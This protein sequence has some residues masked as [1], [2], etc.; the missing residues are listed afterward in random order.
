MSQLS[1]PTTGTAESVSADRFRRIRGMTLDLTADLSE[2]DCCVQSQTCCSPV[3]WHLGHTSWFFERFIVR[4]ILGADAYDERFEFLFNS[5]YNAIGTRQPRSQRGLLTRPGL[6]E[7]MAFREVVDDRVSRALERGDLDD[8]GLALVELGLSHEQQHQEL[9]LMD[10][11]H[12]FSCSPLGVSYASEGRPA[13]AD[14]GPTTDVAF[15]GQIASIGSCFGAHP[16]IFDN[17]CPE[18]RVF[19]EPFTLADRLVTN[20]EYLEF[21]N[22]GGYTRPDHWLDLGWRV[23][24]TAGWSSPAYWQ[25]VNGEWHEFT[26][27]G[28]QPIDLASPVVHVSYFE[29]DAFAR[30]AGARLPTEFEL[31]L[32]WERGSEGAML[33]SRAFHPGT[34]CEPDGRIRQLIGDTWEWTSSSYGPYPGY[35]KPDGAVGEYNGKF[36]CN[37]YVLR[38]GSCVTPRDHIRSTYRNYFEPEARWQ[39]AGI[40]LARS[41]NA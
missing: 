25:Q 26:L 13:P 4:Q 19:V 10:V 15:D 31:E 6:G 11:K 22:D 7:I 24:G 35:C 37:Q 23:A 40:R 20:G 29:A 14:P 16:A 9:L 5:Y 2:E 34:A 32:A 30:W 1:N 3:K 18:H 27:Y 8:D 17:E 28:P 36:M 33:C 39:F 12:L 41:V 21:I 38:G